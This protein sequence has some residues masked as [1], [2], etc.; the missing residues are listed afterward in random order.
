MIKATKIAYQGALITGALMVFGAFVW[1]GWFSGIWIGLIL[2]LIIIPAA[3]VE[4][5]QVFLRQ[6]LEGIKVKDLMIKSSMASPSHKVICHPD[7]E[8]M[9]VLREMLEKRESFALVKDQETIVGIITL[10]DIDFYIS[11]GC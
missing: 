10:A 9:K 5:R 8:I 4:Y 2:W 11:S 3:R 1:W 7:D 6:K